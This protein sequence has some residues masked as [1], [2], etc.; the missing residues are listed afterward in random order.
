MSTDKLFH[1]RKDYDATPLLREDMPDDPFLLFKDWFKE[2]AGKESIEANAMTLATVGY[3]MVPSARVVL[4]KQFSNDGFVFFTNY[5]SRKGRQIEENPNAS[6]LFFW[7]ISMRQVRIEGRVKKITAEE[8]D[9]YFYSRPLESQI[10]A[11]LSAQSSPL[12]DREEFEQK[13]MSTLFQTMENASDAVSRPEHWGGYIV[14][15]HSFE[16]WQGGSNRLHD[17]F[18]YIASGDKWDIKRLYP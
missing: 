6:L 7:P 3:D 8:S 9:E 5:H 15:P 4:L 14:E 17:R 12:P 11:A 18:M 1:M 13:I 2:A 10:T 16:F